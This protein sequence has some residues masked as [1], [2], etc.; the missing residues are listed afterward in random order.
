MKNSKIL[1]FVLALIVVA[2]I[3]F[4]YKPFSKN[5]TT[6][7]TNYHA[8]CELSQNKP[9]EN[10]RKI[11]LQLPWFASGEHSYIYYGKELNVFAAHGFDVKVK[12]GR[13]SEVA[14]RALAAGAVDVAIAGGDA[15]TL[16][17]TEG[18]SVRSIGAIYKESPVT[19]Y[20]LK[21]K[22][23]DTLEKLYGKKVG[24]FSGSNTVLQYAGLLNQEGI[25]RSRIEE[26]N[27]NPKLA[28]SWIRNGQGKTK[29][30]A[31]NNY[32]DAVV[33]YTHFQPLED[34]ILLAGQYEFSEILLAGEGVK[35]YGMTLAVRDGKFSNVELTNLRNA[36]YDSF[37]CGRT[38]PDAAIDSLAKEFP[39]YTKPN[40]RRLALTQFKKT[41]NMSCHERGNNCEDFLDQ[42]DQY[43]LETQQ[44]L[45]DFGLIKNPLPLDDIRIGEFSK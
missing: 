31:G 26:I 9:A 37:Q 5:G 44:Q 8:T 22:N 15:L 32:L 27:V 30:E 38:N 13:G 40:D 16:I 10:L 35:I 28:P 34:S 36:V 18:G 4:F 42:E 39:D 21:E 25:D 23:I 19:I 1:L 6:T 14:A 41:V 33:H 2:I 17:N 3:L 29:D 45:V 24:L 7:A 20:S 11:E 12:T 43:W